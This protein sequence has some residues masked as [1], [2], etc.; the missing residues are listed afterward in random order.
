MRASVLTARRAVA[1]GVRQRA[2]AAI[3]V[4]LAPL[5]A[6]KVVC[7]F[8]PIPGEP[9]GAPLRDVLAGA[10]RLLLPVLLPDNDL[11]WAV[12]DGGPLHPAG[13]GL[14]EPSGPRLGVDA[15]TDA[16]LVV[17]PAVAVDRRGLRLGRGGGSYDRALARAAGRVVAVVYAVEIVPEVPAEAHDRPVHAAVTEDGLVPF[18][19]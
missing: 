1:P 13:R 16:E 4:A 10:G 18:V 11:D 3:A 19:R 5:V 17:V 6:G 8:D 2:D 12:H 9:G 7:A 14:R 15:I